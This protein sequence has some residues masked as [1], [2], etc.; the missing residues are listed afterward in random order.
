MKKYLLL[1]VLLLS[2]GLSAYAQD[3]PAYT[4]Q[5]G[6]SYNSKKISS[7]TDT[8]STTVNGF[9]WTIANFN[10]NNNGWAFVKCGSKNAASVATITTATPISEK[11]TKIEV[12]IDAITASNVNS[13]TLKTSTSSDFSNPI[14]AKDINR[15]TGTQTV[16]LDI[17]AENLYYQ[18]SFDCKKSSNGV[19]QISKVMYYAGEVTP[20]KPGAPTF[21]INGET[22]TDSYLADY[23]STV[24]VTVS[25]KGA[26][27]LTFESPEGIGTKTG[28]SY[29]LTIK[30]PTTITV[31]GTNGEGDGD[32]STL[33]ITFKDA[34]VITVDAPVFSFGGTA[35][36]SSVEVKAGS[37]ITAATETSGATVTLTASPADAA[38]I[39]GTS[40][41]INAACQLTATA[42]LAGKTASSTLDVTIKE[43][44]PVAAGAFKLLTDL[45]DLKDGMEVILAYDTNAVSA[46]NNN[47]F[48]A[49]K[50]VLNDEKNVITDNG[51][52]YIFTLSGDN[53]NGWHFEGKDGCITAASTSSTNVSYSNSTTTNKIKITKPGTA[54]EYKL[55][56]TLTGNNSRALLWS[57]EANP[58]VFGHYATSNVGKGKYFY[59]NIYYRDSATEAPVFNVAADATFET[60]SDGKKYYTNVFDVTLTSPTEGAV[61]YYSIDDADFVEY[62]APITVDKN[63]TIKAYAEKEGLAKSETVEMVYALRTARPAIVCNDPEEAESKTVTISSAT[64]GAYVQ[65][66]LDNGAT[67]SEPA[68]GSVV[69]TFNEM[70]KTVNILARAYSDFDAEGEYSDVA[71]DQVAIYPALKWQPFELLTDVTM[72]VPGD[73]IIFVCP[74]YNMALVPYK[75]GENNCKATPVTPAAQGKA[76]AP[77][78]SGTIKLNPASEDVGIY[79]VEKTDDGKFRFKGTFTNGYLAAVAGTNNRLV[80][81]PDNS[82][83]DNHASEATVIVDPMTGYATITFDKDGVSR[84]TLRYFTGNSN[85]FSCYEPSSSGTYDVSIYRRGAAAEFAPR[86]VALPQEGVYDEGEIS[87]V[88]LQCLDADGNVVSDP[89]LSIYYTLDGTDPR[90]GGK[91]YTAPIPVTDNMTVR[92]YAAMDGYFD[93]PSLIASYDIF[94]A[95]KQYRRVTASELRHL[96]ANDDIIILGSPSDEEVVYALSRRQH[97]EDNDAYR[98]AV[99]LDNVVKSDG[100][101]TI[102]KKEVQVLTLIPAV[103]YYTGGDY[104]WRLY[105]SGSSLGAD[106]NMDGYLLAQDNNNALETQ[107]IDT[108]ASEILPNA[109]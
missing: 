48:K 100:R 32:S 19:V 70:G 8:W 2:F 97:G 39:S 93:S 94:R 23:N 92:A 14:E 36:G 54:D 67:W 5:F 57:I 51:D 55:V 65:Y 17:P 3:S 15:A 75:S 87:E 88:T 21:T 7:Y 61:I 86:P 33:D 59:L 108:P 49:A 9:T 58:N 50:I 62:T 1:M 35:L 42:S 44:K 30:T 74:Q 12:V 37:V 47:K 99:R 31:K 45:N 28:S 80:C 11:I 43:E 46:F 60:G 79:K 18:I 72:L 82:L 85:V 90:M 56:F 106:Y 76:K 24:S 68:Q 34:P 38:V 103:D 95:G 26:N 98:E 13:I 25:S 73:E 91:L 66:S 77:D 102:N 89:T 4:C 83:T 78:A 22:V 41:T 20:A 71:E 96:S 84:N 63:Q 16:D 101:I 52:A 29:N 27:E 81:L 40:A 69:L 104:D 107:R 109:D 105:A 10:N 53:T 6:S 64:N